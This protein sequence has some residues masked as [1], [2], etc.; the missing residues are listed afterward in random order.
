VPDTFT[1][2]LNLTQ[3]EVGASADTWGNK[4][5]ADLLALDALFAPTGSGTVVRRDASG[6][7]MVAG[8]VITGPAGTGRYVTYSSG[9]SKRW[10]S[11]VEPTAE[12]GSNAGSNLIMQRFAD[13]GTTVLGV[14]VGIT[15][16]TGV[17]SFEATPQVGANQIYHQGNLPAVIATVSEPVGTV[18]LYAGTN[19]ADPAGG[20]YM[21]CDGRAIS[22]TTFASL[23][24]VVGTSYGVGDGSTTFNIPNTAER[25]IVGQSTTQTLIPQFDARVLGGVFGEGRHTLTTAELAAHN[26]T[27]TDPGHV[28]TLS[29]DIQVDTASGGAQSHGTHANNIGPTATMSSATTGIT[30]NNSGSGTPHNVVQPSLVMNYIIRVK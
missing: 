11:G 1:P 6:N 20:F 16:A 3:P 22:R 12:S 15:R 9:T 19:G 28:H 25:I 18:K 5:N 24:A 8:A 26:H 17:V 29:A 10:L 2:N 7:A 14:S 4:L 13:D 23:F 21:L 30:I 27:I